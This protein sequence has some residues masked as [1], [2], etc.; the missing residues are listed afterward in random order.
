M[1]E[2]KLHSSA[3]AAAAL[4]DSAGQIRSMASMVR[5]IIAGGGKVITFGN[6]GSAAHAMHFTEELMGRYKAD[7][8]PYPA[9]C[10]CDPTV[11]SCIA[12]DFG[13]DEVF[14]R[15]VS[16]VAGADDLLVGFT[17]SGRSKNVSLAIQSSPCATM[18]FSGPK[19][20]Y[21][22]NAILSIDIERTDVIQEMHLIVMHAIL[23]Y[24][25]GKPA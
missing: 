22:T 1:I 18:L 11:M 5:K 4:I 23:E 10:L 15:Q 6:G 14:R 7:R 24:L 3:Q 21:Q 9:I 2:N 20:D 12:N 19:P 25:E 16:A 8:R 17:T 13:W